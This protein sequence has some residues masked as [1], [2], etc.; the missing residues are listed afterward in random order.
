MSAEELVR[1][2]GDYVI[3]T[4]LMKGRML[5]DLNEVELQGL[6][7]SRKSGTAADRCREFAKAF[8]SLSALARHTALSAAASSHIPLQDNN[9]TTSNVGGKGVGKTN[10]DPESCQI[11]QFRGG[12]RGRASALAGRR[13]A[14]PERTSNKTKKWSVLD[15]IKYVWPSS[16]GIGGKLISFS[17]ISFCLMIVYPPLAAFPGHMVGMSARSL[18]AR[19]QECIQYFWGALDKELQQLSSDLWRWITHFFAIDGDPSNPFPV[20]KAM[21]LILSAAAIWKLIT[22]PFF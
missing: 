2:H 12:P 17:I 16:L 9:S 14:S 15:V 22:T 11:V 19:V 4:G 3:A 20:G 18:V 1:Q 10:S 21:S 6:A 13:S 7:A 5:R 8:I